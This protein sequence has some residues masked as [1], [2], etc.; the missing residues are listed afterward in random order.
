VP[1]STQTS[2]LRYFHHDQLGSIAAITDGVTGGEIERLAY[3]PWGKRRNINGLSDVTDSLVGR[4][5]DRGFT[6]HEHLDEMG[7]VHMNGRIYDP[8]VAR[9]MSADPFIQAPS[10]LQ[11]Y[12][13]YAYVMNNPLNLTDPSGYSWLDPLGLANTASQ[14]HTFLS[15]PT[16]NNAF[17][18]HRSMPGIVAVD[19]YV[20]RNRWAYVAGSAIAYYYAGSLGTALHAAYTTRVSTGSANEA[21]R[22]GAI[23]LATSVAFS[24]VGATWGAGSWE[25]Y[26]GHAAVG[27]VSTAAQGGNCGQGALSAAFGKFATNNLSIGGSGLQYDIANGAIAVTAGGV[28]SVIGGGKFANGAETAAY[29]Y[30]FNQL[31]TQK[32]IDIGKTRSFIDKVRESFNYQENYDAGYEAGAAYKQS[33]ADNQATVDARIEKNRDSLPTQKSASGYK[34]F[35]TFMADVPSA[36]W[37]AAGD[38]NIVKTIPFVSGYING[39]DKCVCKGVPRE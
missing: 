13:R 8:L 34:T 22:V 25:N 26:L 21:F 7:V 23:S 5:T 9:F 11:S 4:T 33:L 35:S 24:Y 30:L 12:N 37:E 1:G 2:S 32:P 20:Q 14:V 29:G 3:D 38:R 16:V 6:E 15:S 28:G 36:A 39:Y 17:Y 18:F 10:M 31:T 19:N 27:C